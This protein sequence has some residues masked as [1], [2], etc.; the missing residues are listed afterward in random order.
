[1]EI[2][3]VLTLIVPYYRNPMMLRSQLCEWQGYAQGWQFVVVDDGSPEPA[4]T[5]VREASSEVRERLQLYRI[6]VDIP[7]N[8]GGARNLGSRLA[9]TQWI[10]HVDIDHILPAVCSAD[11]L[12]FRANPKQWY[13]FARFR[14]GRADATRRKDKIPPQ[15]EFGAIHPHVDSYLCTRDLYWRVGGYD[16]D[17]SGCLGGG[18]PFLRQLEKVAGAPGILPAPICLHVHTSTSVPD[19]SDTTLSRD[20]AEY[21]RRRKMKEACRNTKAKNPLR[22]PWERVL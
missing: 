6:G 17:Y 19:A 14:H 22:F 2:L 18:S 11:L 15:Q 21:T 4:E 13:R 10:V 9:D 20:T 16:E 8:R 1:V 7:W 3:S 12:Q 5:I